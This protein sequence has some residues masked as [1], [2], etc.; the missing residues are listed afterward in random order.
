MINDLVNAM[1]NPDTLI[2]N[3]DRALRALFAPAHAVRPSPADGVA[4]A[5]L[6]PEEKARG[7]ALLRVDHTGEICAQALYQGQAWTSSNQ[8]LRIKL[9]DAAKEET[10]HLAWC[11]Q[12]I[13]ELGGRKSYLNPLWFAGSFAIGAFAGLRGDRWNLGFLAETERQVER[14]LA[15]HINRLPVADMKSRILL[16]Q[17]RYDEAKHAGMAQ[18]EGAAKLPW[19]IRNGMRAASKVMTTVAYWV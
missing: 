7:S 8:S 16:D 13:A 6:T 4:E 15:G 10:D 9:A 11:A 12:R 19:P 2:L 1:L 5:P 18:A 14:H 17:M 3:F